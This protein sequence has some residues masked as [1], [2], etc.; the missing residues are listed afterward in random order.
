MAND[1]QQIKSIRRPLAPESIRG[2]VTKA[3]VVEIPRVVKRGTLSTRSKED[4]Q[5]SARLLGRQQI[6]QL[7]SI[8]GEVRLIRR[9]QFI[10]KK[11]TI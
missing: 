11:S 8:A 1:Y 3:S 7:E 9:D 10:S 4:R 2:H 5:Q 6:I